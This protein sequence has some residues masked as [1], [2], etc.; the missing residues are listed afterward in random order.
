M[1]AGTAVAYGALVRTKT[2]GAKPVKA[3]AAGIVA[4]AADAN[5][6]SGFR[7]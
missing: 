7:V 1:T 3:T 6:I 5:L 4:S 2:F